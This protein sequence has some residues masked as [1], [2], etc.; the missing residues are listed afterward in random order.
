MECREAMGKSVCKVKESL[1][2]ESWAKE[3][4]ISAEG[5]VGQGRVG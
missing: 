2:K 1:N 3:V 4:L 5:S